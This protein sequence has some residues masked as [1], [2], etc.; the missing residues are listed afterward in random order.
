MY[1]NRNL[2]LASVL[3]FVTV[4]S[5]WWLSLVIIEVIRDRV[6]TPVTEVFQ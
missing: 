4:L 1:K 2:L 3:L 6:L 5:R